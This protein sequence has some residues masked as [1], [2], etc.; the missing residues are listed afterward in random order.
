M[1]DVQ[2]RSRATIVSTRILVVAPSAY[3]LG[4]LASWLNY[5]LPGLQ[6]TG[7]N[8]ILGLVEGASFHK[9]DAYLRHHPFDHVERISCSTAT[10]FGRR[11]AI[12]RTIKRLKPN[13]V[14]SVNIPECI[15]AAADLRQHSTSS[16]RTIV[17]C[18]G[19]QQDLFAD[20]NFM[21][22]YIDGVACTN[23][24]ACR[25]AERIGGIAGTRVFYA[26]CGARLPK[27]LR[28]RSLAQR[29]IR[30]LFL[31]RLEQQQKR[32][33]DLVQIVKQLSSFRE[34]PWRLQIAGDGP[35]LENL[36]RAFAVMQDN[37]K[38]EFLGH[39]Q[40]N[41][42]AERLLP[43][44]HALIMPSSWET[45]PIVI[46]E[47]MAAGV[48]V[49]SS[50]YLGSGEEGALVDG[51]NCMMF[52]VGDTQTA[53]RHLHALAKD[54]TLVD[55]ISSRARQMVGQRYSHAVS[56]SHWRAAI[57]ATLDAPPVNRELVP[58]TTSRH[59]RIDNV[60]PP[61][62]AELLRTLSG[63]RSRCNDPGGEWPHTIAGA[64]MDEDAFLKLAALLDCRDQVVA[65]Q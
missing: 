64:T 40:P 20:L 65:P 42:I 24:L 52:D 7:W 15:Q 19:I 30:V 36:Q 60:L 22:G 8:M 12:Q 17:T 56:V 35:E 59:G 21:A 55:R 45:G 43:E 41:A 63:R 4:G 31:G 51:V 46:W 16:L 50:R 47:A 13:A 14:V 38:V 9:P 32:V 54:Q 6:Q 5:A 1:Q 10:A 49:V 11:R 33:H 18:H 39:V 27:S 28:P 58:P 57:E 48:P 26:P 62:L 53:A 34:V 2:L 37:V 44:S 61:A 25:L 29:E 23:Q 3:T